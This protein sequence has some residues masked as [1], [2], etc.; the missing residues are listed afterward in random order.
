MLWQG[1]QK[2]KRVEVVSSTLTD[3]YGRFTALACERG[4]GA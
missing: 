3:K 2:P 4:F 1:F